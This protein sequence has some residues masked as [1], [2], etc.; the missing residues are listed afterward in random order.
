MQE[1]G[2]TWLY[3]AANRVASGVVE[4]AYYVVRCSNGDVSL[5]YHLVSSELRS[6][7]NRTRCAGWFTAF[8]G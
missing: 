1:H 2:D 4:D 8:E 6:S 7:S 5:R 3:G